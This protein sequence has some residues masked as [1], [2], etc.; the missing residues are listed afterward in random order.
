VG[1]RC[2]PWEDGHLSAFA[3]GILAWSDTVNGAVIALL[4]TVLG[5]VVGAFSALVGGWLARRAAREADDRRHEHERRLQAD[6][7]ERE[8]EAERGVARGIARV[9]QEELK[10]ART[11]MQTSLELGEWVKADAFSMSATPHDL[12]LVASL[13]NSWSP[14]AAAM[15]QIRWAARRSA[16]D[17]RERALT[18][19]DLYR[20]D[21]SELMVEFA[22]EELD[23]VA[24]SEVSRRLQE[25]L[26]RLAIDRIVEGT[27]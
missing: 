1:A 5:I 10:N 18:A 3:F 4:G 16:P 6:K 21:I 14:V 11:A 26:D 23:E 7:I 19:D 15:Q 12:Q 27:G 13:A 20:L 2:V 24:E 8:R 17:N 25:Q 22:V 9:M